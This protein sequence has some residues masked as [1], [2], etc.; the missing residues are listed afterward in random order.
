MITFIFLSG[1]KLLIDP[2]LRM[3]YD[4]ALKEFKILEETEECQYVY[5]YV[6]LFIHV[7]YNIMCMLVC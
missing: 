3:R 6:T 2:T 5:M 7:C 1:I 4:K